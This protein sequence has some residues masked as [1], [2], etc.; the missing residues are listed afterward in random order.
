M[1]DAPALQPSTRPARS[2][3][4]LPVA[5]P[6]FPSFDFLVLVF[7]RSRSGR[8][9][10]IPQTR[11]LCAR[12]PTRCAMVI[13]W[14]WGGIAAPRRPLGRE[15]CG[16]WVRGEP[17]GINFDLYNLVAEIYFSESFLSLFFTLNW[18]SS[19]ELDGV[20]CEASI[21]AGYCLRLVT[22]YRI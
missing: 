22:K 7:F 16:R 13:C 21:S 8:V 9:L 17:I 11:V 2:I 14:A 20:P 19:A 15:C 10:V 3:A 12:R 18:C 6:R 1:G 5:G 4:P